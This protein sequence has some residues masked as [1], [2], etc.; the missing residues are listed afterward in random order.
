MDKE[1]SEIKDIFCP[2]CSKKNAFINGK[3]IFCNTDI[4]AYYEKSAK[5][6]L[7]TTIIFFILALCSLSILNPILSFIFFFLSIISFSDID[8]M[9]ENS[10]D[11]SQISQNNTK[12]YKEQEEKKEIQ[13][14]KNIEKKILQQQENKKLKNL[15]VE[16]SE[17]H[18]FKIDTP[19]NRKEILKLAEKFNFINNIESEVNKMYYVEAKKN[20][21]FCNY[22]FINNIKNVLHK[23]SIFSFIQKFDPSYTLKTSSSWIE[24]YFGDEIAEW[25]RNGFDIDPDMIINRKINSSKIV[26][27]IQYYSSI[28]DIIKNDQ[29]LNIICNNLI[30][31]FVSNEN[32]NYGY[33]SK[34]LYDIYTYSYKEKYLFDINQKDF[35]N[36]FILLSQKRKSKEK[37]SDFYQLVTED[38]KEAGELPE[39]IYSKLVNKKLDIYFYDYILYNYIMDN[40]DVLSFYEMCNLIK[41]I[42]NFSTKYYNMIKTE[43][44]EIKR[45]K[46]IDKEMKKTL[47]EKEL[48]EQERLRLLNG[49]LSK[50]MK[51]NKN[52]QSY[53][54]NG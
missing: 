54:N 35:N 48:A 4:K 49:D 16:C 13:R 41:D 40:S 23:E 12:L 42:D 36:C 6:S 52:L 53:K 28:L 44:A 50:E 31:A 20:I 46:Q 39:K 21:L 26:E 5:H 34:K 43:K 14:T 17:K 11:F 19:E 18:L 25:L 24:K 45:Q 1:K 22:T 27:C 15:Y 8:K 38:Y 2:K 37:Y 7:I 30:E 9:K 29:E 10:K 32:I 33:C 47:A 3:C 51:L